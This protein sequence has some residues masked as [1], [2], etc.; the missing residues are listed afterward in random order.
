MNHFLLYGANGYTGELVARA[1]V[2][3]GL[4]PRLA[5]RDAD[6]V[7]ALAGQLRLDYA[8]VPLDDSRKLRHL[9]EEVPAVLHCAGPFV[10]T[11][12]PM[13]DAC[14][15][16][17]THY[18]DITGEIAVFESLAARHDEAVRMQVMLLPGCGFDVVPSD[19]LA[20]HLAR[21]LP[22]AR[23]L[24]IG[25]MGLGGVSR[26][27]ARTSLE[28]LARGEAG[29]V[30]RDGRLR[31]VPL[32]WKTAHI[33]FGTGPRMAVTMP[34]GDVA[35][36]YHSTGIPDVEVYMAFPPRTVRTL[37]RADMLRR[38]LPS[39]ILQI[40]GNWVIGRRP[41]GPDEAR[42]SRGECRLWGRV[43]DGQGGEASARMR[44]PEAYT[45]TADA[46]LAIVERVLRG[47]TTP[48]FQTPSRA[49]GPDFVLGLEG[50]TRT[51]V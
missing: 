1:A 49:C 29:M 45:F 34:W 6:A 4:R 19:C 50:V 9:L 23:S 48:G 8:A 40:A 14:L 38:L 10:H 20:A 31:Q 42:R 11:S 46:A 27:T 22:G 7:R 39:R 35:T 21:R 43:R 47:E 12:A 2:S 28:S 18:L 51:D 33:D 41:P 15:R 44:T 5:G 25:I 37:R 30:R 16:T 17:A 3:R 26:G 32:A 24:E 36:A 13:V